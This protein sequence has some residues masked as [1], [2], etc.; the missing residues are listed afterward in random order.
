M[1]R[2]AHSRGGV[3]TWRQAGEAHVPATL[4]PRDH[5]RRLASRGHRARTAV[6]FADAAGTETDLS[7]G[8]L[9][10][11]TRIGA[12]VLSTGTVIELAVGGL[13]SEVRVSGTGDLTLLQHLLGVGDLRSVARVEAVTLQVL[14]QLSV[15]N[16]R[17]AVR[18]SNVTLGI[19]GEGPTGVSIR[20]D[21]EYVAPEAIYA[22]MGGTYVEVTAVWVKTNGAY[23]EA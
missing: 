21:G 6:G 8:D 13:R 5:H 11:E 14:G 9:R 15:Q 23:V 4:A 1:L 17:S 18:M 7:L 12:V 2:Y 22:K 20:V 19:P 16:L 10:S 3:W